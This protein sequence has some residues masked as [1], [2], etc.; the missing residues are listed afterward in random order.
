MKK[1]YI[2]L[3]L[4]WLGIGLSTI[5]LIA[6]PTKAAEYLKFSVGNRQFSIPVEALESYVRDGQQS[7]SEQLESYTN[8]LSNTRQQQVREVLSSRYEFSDVEIQQILNS[9]MVADFLI[10]VGKII[11]ES[12]GENGSAA[13]R[14]AIVSASRR[15]GGLSL[16]DIIREFPSPSIYINISQTIAGLTNVAI[17]VE[18]TKA[19][20]NQVRQLAYSQATEK[21]KLDFSELPDL[22]ELGLI[23]SNKQTFVI[24]DPIRHREYAVDFYLPLTTKTNIPTIIISHG[25]ASDRSRFE[26]VARHFASYGFAVAVPQHPGSD[27]QKFQD[28]LIGKELDLFDPQEFINR[29]LDVSQT[30][31]YLE[32]LNNNEL[33]NRLNLD[34]VGIIGHSLGGYTAMVLAGSPIDFSRL[35]IDCNQNKFSVNPSLFLQCRALELPQNVTNFKDDRINAIVLLNPIN[36]SILGQSSI[37]KIDIPVMMVASGLDI[38]APAVL[39]QV[40]AFNWLTTP[41]RYFVLK[42][43]N[44][45]FFDINQYTTETIP[46]LGGF[47]S[48][49]TEISQG[50]IKSLSLAFF[51]THITNN[52]EYQQYLQAAY[53]IHISDNTYPIHFILPTPGKLLGV[54]ENKLN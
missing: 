41:S 11:Q 1:N 15:P 35:K 32:I 20:T 48:P 25:L 14:A 44:S 42:E 26:S 9:P 2:I 16:M 54:M 24:N 27:F 31:D 39:E 6:A 29:P 49:A 36:S 12:S 3:L 23:I 34:N 21:P 38:L 17:L 45:H 50:Y 53:A 5:T 33:D 4:K 10:Q 40:Q 18:E 19:M 13:I 30:L 43:K 7:D 47:T 22:R 28:L 37:A 46:S 52:P 8:L 51:Q